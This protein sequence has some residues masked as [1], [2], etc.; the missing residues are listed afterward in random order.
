[1]SAMAPP[2][3]AGET[4]KERRIARADVMP[5]RRRAALAA[6]PQ[7]MIGEDERHHRLADRHRANADAGVA[8]PGDDPV[9]PPATITVL[10]RG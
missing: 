3:P 9:S 1:M 2:R 7:H 5:T 6:M 10:L 8:G 4:R